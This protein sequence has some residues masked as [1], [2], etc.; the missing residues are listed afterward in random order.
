MPVAILSLAQIDPGQFF[1]LRSQ[2]DA[3]VHRLDTNVSSVVVTNDFTGRVSVTTADGD[4]VTLSTNVAS[5][6]LAV[7]YGGQIR[8][9][10]AALS[11]DSWTVESRLTREFGVTIEGDLNEQEL[12]DLE[13]LFRKISNIFRGF[14]EEQSEHALVLTAKLAER[15][16]SLSSL[17]SLDLNVDVRRTIEVLAAHVASEVS[18][19]TPGGAPATGAAI[20]QSSNGTTA[21]TP[22]SNAP[23][24]THLTVPVN[25]APLAL[26]IQQILDALK[27]AKVESEK[28]RKYL[29]DFLE[30]LRENLVKELRGERVAKPDDRNRSGAQVSNEGGSPVDSS[31]LLV[32]YRTFAETSSSLSLQS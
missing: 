29:P 20:P 14:S 15:F 24:G 9:D 2:S 11:V 21:P 30:K 25:D 22:S 19:N 31:S 8:T 3:L 16:G 6:F 7:N 1:N 4:R 32:A 12:R 23:D 28:V 5:D 27:E 26:L 17:S 18:L 13:G 10:R